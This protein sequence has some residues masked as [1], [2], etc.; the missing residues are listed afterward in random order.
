MGDLH[1]RAKVRDPGLL[2]PV[3]GAVPGGWTLPRCPKASKHDGVG[4]WRS[5]VAHLLGVQGVASS[6]LAAPIGL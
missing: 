2:A 4:A 1:D 3:V 6:N 5:L